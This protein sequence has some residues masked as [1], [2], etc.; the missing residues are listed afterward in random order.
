[1]LVPI[2]GPLP[3]PIP[4]AIE[5]SL[6]AIE[7]PALQLARAPLLPGVLG[8]RQVRRRLWRWLRANLPAVLKARRAASDANLT[9]AVR[10]A[11]EQFQRQLSALA[12][13]AI[14]SLT[15]EPAPLVAPQDA[16]FAE[17][18]R[19]RAVLLEDVNGD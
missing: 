1:V 8:R 13:Q 18:R 17:L 12:A 7:L 9:A 4:P 10:H 11:E 6:P 14:A 15:A 16:P 3:A 5:P 19:L 2:I